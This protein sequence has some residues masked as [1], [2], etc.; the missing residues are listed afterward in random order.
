MHMHAYN[1]HPPNNHQCYSM[2]VTHMGC[3]DGMKPVLPLFSCHSIGRY[4]VPMSKILTCFMEVVIAATGKYVLP[5]YY[6]IYASMYPA[7]LGASSEGSHFFLKW[8]RQFRF[9]FDLF[10]V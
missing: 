9:F 4:G 2:L 7:L 5:T 10:L 1:H 8:L 3:N 6:L